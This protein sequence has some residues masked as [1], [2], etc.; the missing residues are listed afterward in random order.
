MATT[1]VNQ[2]VQPILQS[3]KAGRYPASGRRFDLIVSVLSLWIVA[4]LYLDGSA[5]H[6]IPD[7]IETFF[8][9][10]H[11]VLYSGFAASAGLLLITQWRNVSKGYRWTRSLPQGYMTSLLGSVIFLVSGGADFLWHTAFGFEV[12]LEALVSP[13]H[14]ALAVGGVLMISGPL[15]ATIHRSTQQVVKGWHELL[16]VVLSLLGILSVLTFFN[17]D[18][19]IITYPNFMAIRPPGSDT[20]FYDTH[21]LASVLIP[22][23]LLMGVIL[24]AL[25]HWTLPPGSLTVL[26]YGN[27]LLMTWFHLKEVYL[28]PQIL[29][30][31]A[32]TGIAADVLYSLLRPSAVRV[33]ALRLFAF[34]VP[35]ILFALFFVILITTAGIW[36]SVHLWTGAVFLAGVVGLLLSYLTHPFNDAKTPSLLGAIQ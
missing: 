14:L 30:A 26:I 4:G 9:P 35:A 20:F 24:F 11:A 12:G 25:W 17:G 16:P 1:H 19:A 31:I 32:L 13:S 34:A 10:W 6:H 21:A 29:F 28:N 8:T 5:H 7:L 22:S 18:F 27:G 36:W 3:E 15:R 33:R 23:A 2:D